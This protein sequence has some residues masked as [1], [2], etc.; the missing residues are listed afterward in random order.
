[1]LSSQSKAHSDPNLIKLHPSQRSF[2]IASLSQ[3]AYHHLYRSLPSTPKLSLPIHRTSIISQATITHSYLQILKIAIQ[4][5]LVVSISVH[6]VI[7]TASFALALMR[8]NKAT[9]KTQPRSLWQ[10][11]KVALLDP[12]IVRLAAFL[13]S[14]SA[15]WTITYPGLLKLNSSDLTPKLPQPVPPTLSERPASDALKNRQLA[16]Q[17]FLANWAA[18]LSGAVAGLALLAQTKQERVNLAPNIFCRGLYTL[19]KYR[20]LIKFPH[21]DLVLF[22]ISNA[23]IMSAFVLNPQTLPSWYWH[24]IRNVG[25]LD[26]KFLELHRLLNLGKLQDKSLA[27]FVIDRTR[28]RTPGNNERL[29]RWLRH[30]DPLSLPC[31]PC[32][33]NHPT[34]DSCVVGN[35][36]RT[37]GA[38]KSML[39]TYAILHLVPA[40]LFRSKLF[41]KSPASFL[42]SIARKTISSNLFL[43]SFAW[44]IL[45][46]VC[47]PSRLY[48]SSNG[49]IKLRGVRWNGAIGFAT[50]LSLLWEDPRRRTELALYCAPKALAS[51][52]FVMRNRGIVKS[53][54][55]GEMLIAS[56]GTAMLMH[57]F[58]HSPQTMPALIRGTIGQL[59]D[60]HFPGKKPSTPDR[61]STNAIRAIQTTDRDVDRGR[62]LDD[63][64]NYFGE[65]REGDRSDQRSEQ[66]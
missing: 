50:T 65:F 40:L 32:H 25:S 15:L 63:D 3:N 31:A 10:L 23:Q 29:S 14:Y 56:T 13:G 7:S 57:C 27:R 12:T 62:M 33:F 64:A 37:W 17:R 48:E 9:S 51:V 45:F 11:I 8:R 6:S 34:S 36:I 21:G 41:M 49:R 1:M 30:P 2:S 58:I 35:G 52:W 46:S 66:A 53:I 4:K 55:Y 61:A 60:P 19:L 20:P 22:G 43:A 54:K 28:H 5:L 42:L 16:L 44:I 26:V 47:I 59:I 24:W 38:F 39:P 18:A